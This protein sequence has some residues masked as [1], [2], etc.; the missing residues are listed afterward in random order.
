MTGAEPAKILVVQTGFLGDALLT[1]PLLSGL[2]SRFPRADIAVLCTPMA[3]SLLEGNPDIDEIIV[4]DKKGDGRGWLGIR[5]RARQ[6]RDRGFALAL[7]PH[8][9]ARS[10]LLLFLAGIPQRIGFRQSGGW[11][12]YHH[13]VAWDPSLHEVRRN[14]SLL[15]PLGAG[16]VEARGPRI[17]ISRATKQHVTKLLDSL[18]IGEAETVFGIHPGSVWPTKRW[19]PESYA[20]LVVALKRRFQC[21]VILF[22]GADDLA[23]VEAVQR[24][25]GGE[26]VSLAGKLDLPGFACALERCRVFV[27]N[28]SAPMHAAVA[29][30]VPVVAVFC[31]TTPAL[32]F[33]PY[34]SRAVVVEKALDCRP[35][36]HHGGRRCPLGTEECIHAI[37]PEDVLRGVERLFDGVQAPRAGDDPHRP[38]FITL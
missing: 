8:K 28:D 27:T 22:G 18:G 31:A 37:R 9:S 6:L 16:P 7:S 11:F 24:S 25:C 38:E 30:G 4:D 19:R 5:R 17:E 1:T 15:D 14:L 26:A 36:S 20:E 33:Y 10:A 23:V 3:R 32:G 2:R 21:K 12:L 35:C 34:S 29:R 13:R